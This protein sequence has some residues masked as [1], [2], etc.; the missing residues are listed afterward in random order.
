MNDLRGARTGADAIAP[1]CLLIM[2]MLWGSTFFVLHDILTRI[3]AADLLAVRFTIAAV[4]FG[5]VM[6]RKLIFTRVTIRQGA[7][8]GLLYG[9]AQLVQ[10][11]GLAHTSAS[12]SGFLTG[13]YVIMTPMLEALLLKARVRQ[14]VWVSVAL[15]TLGLA[16]LTIVP[17][18]GATRFGVGEALTIISALLYALH[19]I[20]TGRV[21]TE[22]KA[23]TLATLQ[24]AG[25]AV[26]CFIAAI[27]GGIALPQ[28]SADWGAVAYLAIIC[29]GLTALM[30]VW[31]QTRVSPA[32]AAVIMSTEPIWAAIFAIL[33]G[34][35]LFSVR[36]LVGGTAMF[37]AM[38]LSS[39]PD[40]TVVP[41]IADAEPA[42]V[43]ETLAS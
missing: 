3:D 36:T 15:A 39:M 17:G 38:V 35:E 7:M 5:L 12:I 21:A 13:T 29:G 2:A 26:L 25:V 27:P 32:R 33:V 42:T 8:L 30:Q 16:A 41:S 18:A 4:F 10:T 24:T 19:I 40:K 1:L 11:Y 22:D 20:Y 43:S 23:I 6:H 9:G 34:Q 28:G 31:A 14:R 37:I